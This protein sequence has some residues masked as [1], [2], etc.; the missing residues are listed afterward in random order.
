MKRTACYVGPDD[1]QHEE[2]EHNGRKYRTMIPP[3]TSS[4]KDCPKVWD[5]AVSL[6]MALKMAGQH[7]GYDCPIH[8]KLGGIDE[9]PLC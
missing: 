9:C 6:A 2:W 3:K 5:G 1:W 8:G 4:N 7:E